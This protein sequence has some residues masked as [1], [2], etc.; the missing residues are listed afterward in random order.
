M[1]PKRFA[2]IGA[3]GYIAPRH[4]K[5]IRDT[6]HELVAACD[7][8][9]SVGVMDSY[10]PSAAFFIEFERFDRHLE[11]LKRVG[12][13]IDYL[14]VC[15]P[16]YL[17]DAHVRYGLRLGADVICE[18]PLVL[19]PWN[20]DAIAVI[21]QET[22]KRVWN[23]LQLRLHPNVISLQAYTASLPES[24]FIDAE[25]TYITP[26]GPWYF[27]SWKGDT[28]KSGGIMTNI[29]IHLFD[30]LLLLFGPVQQTELH[31]HN[32]GRAAGLLRF[33]RASVRW[34]LSIDAATIPGSNRPVRMLRLDQQ[35]WD[36]SE[37]FT[38][39]HTESY[40]RI[41]T[42][43]GYGITESSRS[44]GLVKQLREMTAVVNDVD[45]QHPLCRLPLTPHPFE[46]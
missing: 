24:Q 17:H 15:S 40:Q 12:T 43:E 1:M 31:L 25:L 39:L 2:L 14:V 42:G 6:G 8:N 23:I 9:D 34:F 11:K 28:S 13:G 38:D 33:Q 46:Q 20:L 26:R 19:N 4:M 29:G 5:A 36:F 21:E 32:H 18:K 10:F 7:P 41:L 22:R 27:A 30:L 16:N 3:A 35:T 44:I 37:G 45:Q